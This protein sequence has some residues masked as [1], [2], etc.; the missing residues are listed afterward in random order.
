MFIADEPGKYRE[1]RKQF[2]DAIRGCMFGGA[3]GDALGYPVEFYDEARIESEFG[4]AGIQEYRLDG[5]TGKALL[6]DDTQMSLFTANGVLIERSRMQES[7]ISKQISDYVERTYLDWLKTQ[8]LTFEEVQKMDKGH[9][10]NVVSWLCE[11]PELFSRRSPGNTCLSALKLHEEYRR[12][13]DSKRSGT[14]FSLEEYNKY[15][16][17]ETDYIGTPINDSKGCGGVMRVAPIGL[18][19][20]SYYGETDNL[21]WL[22]WQGAACA[23]VTHGHPLGYLPAAI[24]VHIIS[25]AV[26]G[27]K[28]CTLPEI[29][30]DAQKTVGARFKGFEHLDEMNALLDRAVELAGNTA[31]DLSNIHSLGEGWVAEEALAIAVYCSVRYHDDFT[32]AVTA[33]VNHKGDSDSTGAITGNIVGAMVG[34][35]AI[36]DKWKK[37]LELSD[38]ILEMADDMC[39][40]DPNSKD[41]VVDEEWKKK[42]L[43]AERAVTHP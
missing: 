27:E 2:L 18:A 32:K 35:D 37:N 8:T 30:K 11:V 23:A 42:Y 34:Y 12:K 40:L 10:K 15:Y 22:D 26:F 38:V 14:A 6:S 3:A 29:I 17:F 39:F 20:D 28:G 36:E 1:Y 9:A 7:G 19:F 21:A 13:I 43:G 25:R 4:K 31:D 24:L 5:A 41:E 33:A 16:P